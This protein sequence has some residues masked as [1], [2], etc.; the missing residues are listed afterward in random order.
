MDFSYTGV[1]T[2]A[3][4]HQGQAIENIGEW[5][6]HYGKIPVVEYKKY[7]ADFNPTQ[8]DPEGMGTHG[9][10][11]WHEVHRNHGEAPRWVRS[12]RHRGE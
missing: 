3:G 8:Y 6:M 1:S 12:V 5:I 11:C 7:A 2:P 10:G 9:Q 4:M